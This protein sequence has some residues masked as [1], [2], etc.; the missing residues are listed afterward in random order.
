M[1]NIENGRTYLSH[2]TIRSFHRIKKLIQTKE[3][4]TIMEN[5]SQDEKHCAHSLEIQ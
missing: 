2:F 3:E 1:R 5:N 4:K